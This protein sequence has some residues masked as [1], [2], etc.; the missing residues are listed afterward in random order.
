MKRFVFLFTLS[1]LVIVTGPQVRAECGGDNGGSSGGGG[2]DGGGSDGASVCDDVSS[3]VGHSRCTRFGRWDAS[4]HRPFRLRIGTS[5]V[6]LGNGPTRFTG[7][8]K[9]PGM[10]AVAYAVQR[11]GSNRA[12]SGGSFDISVTTHLGDGVGRFLYA[13][14]EGRLGA[15]SS[16]G[17]RGESEAD[18]EVMPTDLSYVSAAAILGTSVPIGPLTLRGELAA[19]VDAIGIKTHTQHL[20]CEHHTTLFE[21]KAALRPRVSVEHWVTPWISMGASLATNVLRK[22]DASLGLFVGGHWQAFDGRR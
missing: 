21:T 5:L 8:A 16:S 15:L 10:P 22:N 2:G 3:V 12:L 14:I 4:H 11:D 17:F 18:L 7:T 13:G 20:D 19:G 6:R 9:H 1:L